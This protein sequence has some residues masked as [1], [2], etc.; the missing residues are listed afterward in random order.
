VSGSLRDKSKAILRDI[1]LTKLPKVS[2]VSS[3][4]LLWLPLD[5][6]K[7]AIIFLNKIPSGGTTILGLLSQSSKNF[8]N[9]K[10]KNIKEKNP[11]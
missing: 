2:L 6:S 4:P 10:T 11:C 7:G 8:H 3:S 9:N 5:S 1:L